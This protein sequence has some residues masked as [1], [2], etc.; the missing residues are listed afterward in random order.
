MPYA[1]AK[2]PYVQYTGANT[3][4]VTAFAAATGTFALLRTEG[5][6]LVFSG[7]YGI[8]QTLNVGDYIIDLEFCTEADFNARYSVIEV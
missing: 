2:H 5:D 7:A 6:A 1:V 4:D 8:E 3:E